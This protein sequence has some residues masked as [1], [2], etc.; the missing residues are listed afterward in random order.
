[1]KKFTKAKAE[2]MVAAVR[3]AH[4][5]MERPAEAVEGGAAVALLPGVT[6][7]F[8]PKV[9]GPERLVCEAELVFAYGRLAGLRLVGLTIWRGTDSGYYVTV[10]S[11][12]FGHDSDRRYFDY[13]RSTTGEQEPVARFKAWV[14]EE[15]ENARAAGTVEG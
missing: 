11:R 7:R 2:A 14:L 8:T 12:A 5:E 6:V 13:L 10:P 4:P 9:T 15:F 3:A 1:M